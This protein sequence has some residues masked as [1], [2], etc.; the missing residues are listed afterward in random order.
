MVLVH[1]YGPY[2]CFHISVP[3]MYDGPYF[4]T[5]CLWLSMF[6]CPIFQCI[7]HIPEPFFLLLILSNLYKKFNKLILY[8]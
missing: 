6:L 2:F 7:V 8:D 3:A 1:F 5:P 4:Y